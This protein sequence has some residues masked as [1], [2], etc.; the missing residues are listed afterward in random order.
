MKERLTIKKFLIV[1]DDVWNKNY[2]NWN[3]LQ[4]P[5]VVG[6]YGSKIIVTARSG[7][8]QS[9]VQFAFIVWDN[10]LLRTDCWSL[11]AEQAFENGDSSPHPKLEEI[12][13]ERVKK[14]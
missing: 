9:C 1:V 4:A 5:F 12:G 14:L 7:L 13:R 2:A 3:I 11:F 10:C 8:H 6:Q